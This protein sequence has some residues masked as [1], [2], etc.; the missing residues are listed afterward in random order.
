MIICCFARWRGEGRFAK[1]TKEAP[2]AV[3]G[4]VEIYQ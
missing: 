3:A 2:L 4:R 1:Q